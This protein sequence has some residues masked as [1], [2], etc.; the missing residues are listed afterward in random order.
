MGI[1]VQDILQMPSLRGAEVLT[2]K[3]NLERT[4]SSLSVLEVS[5]VEFFSRRIQTVQEE[6][7]S[8]ELVISSFYSIKDSVEKQCKA[9]QH[10]HDL[11]ELGL[12]LYY[13]GIIVPEIPEEVLKLADSLDFIIICMPKND[14]S[15]RYNEV[16]YEVMEAIVSNQTINDNFVNEALEKVSLLPEHLRSV[17][18]TLKFLSDRLKANILITNA[19]FDIMNQVMWPRNSSL[20]VLKIIQAHSQN[21][22]NGKT[23]QQEINK[24]ALSCF[25]EYKIIHQKN[26]ERLYLFVIKENTKLPVK[27]IEKISEVVQVAMNLWGDKHAEVSEYALVKAIVNDESDKMRRLANLL[28]IDVSAIEMMWLV[29]I[30][31]LSEEKKIGEELAEQV[32]KYYKTAVIQTIDHC[33]IVLLGNYLYKYPEL[34]IASEFIE[35]TNYFSQISKIVYCPKMRNTLDVRRMYQL[36]NNVGDKVHTIFPVR[37]L[38]TAAEIRSMER[39]IDFSKQGEEKIEEWLSII[40][41]VLKDQDSLKTLLTFLL[42]AKGNFDDCAKLLFVHKNTVKYRIRKISELIGYDVTVN[43]E[44]YDAYIACM[45]YRLLNN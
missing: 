44:S 45:I 28:H 40:S 16:I 11:G 31:D 22:L 33:M 32:T 42:D 26:G 19:N 41:P 12:I 43:S 4:V 30:K 29:Y 21:S 27:T 20:D 1:T 35:T 7:Y 10:L 34:E 5:D 25:V 15:L 9:I 23:V 3:K 24:N 39:A 37:K 18:I 13:V 38:F 6:W 17:E 2:G 14:Y 8:E 36:V